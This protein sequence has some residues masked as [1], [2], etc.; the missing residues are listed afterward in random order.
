MDIIRMMSKSV[1]VPL[2]DTDTM[3]VLLFT[4]ETRAA[5]VKSQDAKSRLPESLILKEL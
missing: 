1:S 4:S 5:V 2:T 3:H